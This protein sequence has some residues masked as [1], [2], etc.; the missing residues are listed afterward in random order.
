M[1]GVNPTDLQCIQLLQGGPL[2]AGELARRT[3]LT[4][5]AVTTMV[6]R[7]ERAGFVI[8]TR[9]TADRRRVSRR[10]PSGAGQRR[11]RAGIPALV[12]AWRD[13]MGAYDIRDLQ[14]IAG[15]L[16]QV[17]EAIDTA[18]RRHRDS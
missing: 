12:S 14:L 16:G 11:G 5:A 10:T 1:I 18:I 3:G 9:D 4:T 2:T 7:L 8:R 6:D 15:F 17:E 13:L